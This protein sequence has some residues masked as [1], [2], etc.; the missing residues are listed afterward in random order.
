M[1]GEPGREHHFPLQSPI[2]GPLAAGNL[3]PKGLLQ[4][5]VPIPINDIGRFFSR[6]P[7]IQQKRASMKAGLQRG[8]Q[9]RIFACLA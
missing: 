5:T 4:A 8:K 6:C 2:A 3:E 1:Y 7:M 9:A